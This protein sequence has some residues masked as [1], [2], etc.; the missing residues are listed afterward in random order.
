MILGFLDRSRRCDCRHAAGAKGQSSCRRRA[1]QRSA[2]WA[3]RSCWD[4]LGRRDRHVVERALPHLH[5]AIH[6]LPVRA[7]VVR[8]EDPALLRLHD[9]VDN[10]RV[11]LRD[12]HADAAEHAG[13]ETGI[14]RNFLPVRT[15]VDRLVETA[16]GT[17]GIQR[18]RSAIGLPHRGIQRARM[19]VVHHEVDRTGRVVDVEHLAPVCTAVD[20]F[21]D[22]TVGVIC[23]DV[24]HRRRVE[25]LGIPRIDHDLGGRVGVL[26][27]GR[28]P[29]L[30]R[31]GGLVDTVA[32]NERVAD[33]GLARTGID[34]V[35]IRGRYSKR[36]NTVGG[37]ELAVGKV[38]PG[39]A[40]VRRAPHAPVDTTEIERKRISG[41]GI[42]R[43]GS[44][45]DAGTDVTP[46]QRAHHRLRGRPRLCG[47]RKG[48]NRHG[49]G[50]QGKALISPHTRSFDAG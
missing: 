41:H 35:R 33:V 29:G 19:R 50:D 46:A 22:A 8:A 2:R 23:V 42:D 17:A 12:A 6:A 40:V 39:E 21:E 43:H 1:R 28:V 7:A 47:G 13:R 9:R 20:R 24:T 16:A 15:A 49:C 38:G 10:L 32:G 26:Q 44:S 45:A 31:V 27:T 36:A 37:V 3:H 18:P 34:D 14:R 30:A 25:D 5:A 11:A 4:R 48:N